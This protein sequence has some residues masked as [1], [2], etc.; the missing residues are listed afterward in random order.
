ML[1]KVRTV[2]CDEKE[3]KADAVWNDF[4]LKVG[5]LV[6]NSLDKLDNIVYI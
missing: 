3:I 6:F 1:L 4:L 2:I 5:S